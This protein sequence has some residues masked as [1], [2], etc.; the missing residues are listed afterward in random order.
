MMT[1]NNDKGIDARAFWQTVLVL[2][3]IALVIAVM[4]WWVGGLTPRG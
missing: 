2:I 1:G 4:T 3:G